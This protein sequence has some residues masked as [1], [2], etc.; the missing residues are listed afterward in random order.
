M[1]E[2][3]QKIWTEALPYQDKRNDEGHA[4]IVTEYALELLR[5]E[6]ADERIVLPAVILHDIGWSQVPKSEWMKLFTSGT[7]HSEILRLRLLHQAHSSKFAKQI[8]TR[9]NY[10]IELVDSILDIISNHDTRLGHLSI[11]DDIVRDADKL[12]RFSKQ[13]FWADVKRRNIN[14]DE[15]YKRMEKHL[16]NPNYLT[17]SSAKEIARQELNIRK[18]EVYS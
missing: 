14:P 7:D 9:V 1:K 13:G 10:P 6:E 4:M 11:E 5:F 18:K 17:L 3:Y 12:W 15:R 16:S 2:I 8:L